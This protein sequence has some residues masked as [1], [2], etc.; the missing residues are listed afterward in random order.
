MLNTQIYHLSYF[1]LLLPH[2]NR[3]SG[4]GPGAFQASGAGNLPPGFTPGDFNLS[5][6]EDE[7]LNDDDIASQTAI[8]SPKSTS[9]D[10]MSSPQSQTISSPLE[11]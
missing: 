11:S 10:E 9:G 4:G 1:C 8:E 5:S 7:E 2:L 6:D 3:Y